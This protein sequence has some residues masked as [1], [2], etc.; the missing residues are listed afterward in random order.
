M[1]TTGFGAGCK[2]II[3]YK[4]PTAEGMQA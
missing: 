1:K 3:G 2:E 4:N